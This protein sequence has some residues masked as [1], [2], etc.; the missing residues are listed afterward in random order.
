MIAKS[1]SVSR[2][3][4]TNG[5]VTITARALRDCRTNSAL[6]DLAPM[7]RGYCRSAQYGIAGSAIN[8]SHWSIRAWADH[9]GIAKSIVHRWF[10][11]F[12]L[13]PHCRGRCKICND[14]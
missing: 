6:A 5:A 14:L 2:V 7:M 11:L 13:Q 9:T 3:G 12:N 8:G 10:R 4:L 1:L